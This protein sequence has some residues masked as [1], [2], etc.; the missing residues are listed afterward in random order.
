MM[1]LTSENWVSLQTHNFL[2]FLLCPTRK[3]NNL[4]HKVQPPAKAEE[5]FSG[6]DNI[7]R[8]GDLG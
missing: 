2:C 8:T 7:H 3:M 5:E 4:L 1:A 6:I